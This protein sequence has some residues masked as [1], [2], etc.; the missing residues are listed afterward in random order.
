VPAHAQVLV[1][2]ALAGLAEDMVV[3]A[4]QGACT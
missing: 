3:A 4:G 2:I 1:A